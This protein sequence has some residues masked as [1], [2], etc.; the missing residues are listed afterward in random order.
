[1]T[2]A[3]IIEFHKIKRLRHI[4]FLL[5]AIAIIA[6][7]SCAGIVTSGLQI[8]EHV[9]RTTTWADLLLDYT[10]I[11]TMISPIMVATIVSRQV[12]IEHN[13]HGWNMGRSIGIT[14]ERMCSAKLL[15]LVLLII[16][17]I[18]LQ[19][20]LILGIGYL[21]HLNGP[22]SLAHWF[23]YSGLLITVDIGFMALHIYLSSV[24]KNQL[25]SV[26]LAVLG[27][28][29]GAMLMSNTSVI[30]TL[31]PW[32]YYTL[33]AHVAYLGNHL[34]YYWPSLWYPIGFLLVSLAVYSIGIHQ[35]ARK[36][37]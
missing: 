27:S 6:I 32:G 24:V 9:T 29:L 22:L 13:S 23:S 19:T 5:S 4:R 33:I 2:H 3:L 36:R 18:L 10:F 12:D 1:M 11:A 34:D 14:V 20:L 16:P 26:G 21:A 35:F 15:M 30:A 37:K 17:T 7:L 25:L 8:D 31:T 28:F